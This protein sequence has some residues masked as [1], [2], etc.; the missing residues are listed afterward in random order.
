MKT[1]GLE[2]RETR[3]WETGGVPA[4]I[5]VVPARVVSVS[6]L[7][8]LSLLAVVA[9]CGRSEPPALETASRTVV[10]VAMSQRGDMQDVAS[11]PGTIVPSRAADLT[12]YATE[13]ATIAELPL[14]EQDVVAIG[15]VLV[16][17]D[18]PSLTQELATLQLEV[19]Q[20]STRLDRAQADLTRQTELFERGITPRV[21]YDAARLEQSAAE[22]NLTSLT[23]R[24]DAMKKGDARSVVRATFPGIVAAVFHQTGDPVRPDTTD[25]ILR[26][27][28]PTRVQVA[29]ELPVAQLARVVA[30]QSASVRAIAGDVSEPATV[31]S[32]AQTIDPAAPTGEVRLSFTNPATLPVDTPVSVELILDR[33]TAAVYVPS[34]AVGRDDLGAYV[35]EAGD[36]GLAHRRTV[37]PGLVTPQL[38]QIASGLDANVRVVLL[39]ADEVTD[40][41]PIMLAR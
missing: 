12:V 11:A 6:R 29:V 15:D 16:R 32:K 4:R 22:S 30:G 38:T 20:A 24:L 37:L 18:I 36:D 19:L 35:M 28:D 2:G 21:T 27:V 1:G 26:V 3:D 7:G 9:A 13:V 17:Y 34:Q 39:G 10:Q 8:F 31:A 23:M 25:P 33:R 5:V 41:M 40:Q 14:K